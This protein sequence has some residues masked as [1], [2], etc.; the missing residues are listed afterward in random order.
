MSFE[1]KGRIDNEDGPSAERWHQRVQASH[2]AESPTLALL[3]FQTDEGVARN[4]GRVGAKNGPNALRAAAANLPINQALNL[5]DDGDIEVEGTD[6]ESAQVKV[7]EWVTNKLTRNEFPIVMGGGHEIAY[8]SYLGWR[9][10]AKQQR[11]LG[12]INLDA[13]LD[14][15]KPNPTGS[16]GTPFYQIA[17]S[18]QQDGGQ[19][20]Y[21]VLGVSEVANTAALFQRAEDLN[22]QLTYDNQLNLGEPPELASQLVDFCNAVDD[23][24]LTI[25]LDV[26]QAAFM[27]AVSAP[28]AGGL[29]LAMVERII[30]TVMRSGKV[31]L[32]D[33]AELNP[34]YDIDSIGSKTAARVLYRISRYL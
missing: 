20:K 31:R 33:L 5:R 15:R 8:A 30:S 26:L 7:A 18:I 28:A 32:A 4:K 22:V 2:K 24:Y 14:L 34:E 12:I 27:P 10:W 23:I 1:W 19:F 17:Q 11:S 21:W 9:R 13:H 3:G 25:D 16:S 6:L 29:S